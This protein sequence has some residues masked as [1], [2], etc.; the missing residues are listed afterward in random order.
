MSS[1]YEKMGGNPF[2]IGACVLMISIL[3]GI[4]A[5]VGTG[6]IWEWTLEGQYTNGESFEYVS[7]DRIRVYRTEIVVDGDVR[8]PLTAV[9]WYRIEKRRVDNG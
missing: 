2:V 4:L 7:R 3:V 5:V 6:L 9:R 1:D 8:I